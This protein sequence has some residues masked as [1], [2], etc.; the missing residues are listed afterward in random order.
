MSFVLHIIVWSL[1]CVDC[2]SLCSCVRFPFDTFVF[3]CVRFPFD[4]FVFMC[5]VCTF[6]TFIFLPSV[7]VGVC[8]CS[9]VHCVCGCVLV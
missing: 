1:F 6:G 9:D 4:T 2:V 5:V 3:M 7:Y 8:W